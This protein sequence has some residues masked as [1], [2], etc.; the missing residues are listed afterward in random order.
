M[1]KRHKLIVFLGILLLGNTGL[2]ADTLE[3]GIKSIS[4]YIAGLSIAIGVLF[5][6]IGWI[7]VKFGDK[8]GMDYVKSV[9]LACI[10]VATGSFV[11]EKLYSMFS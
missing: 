1:L 9:T 11:I 10:G 2:Y 4:I 8:N 3:D 6:T 7:R 5:Y